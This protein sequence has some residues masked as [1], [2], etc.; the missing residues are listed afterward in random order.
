MPSN[1]NY[2]WNFGVL[3]G[4]FLVLQIVTGVVLAMHYAPNALVAFGTTEHIMR[5][6]NWGWLMRYAHANGASFFFIVAWTSI[7]VS[8]PK[9]T[10]ASSSVIRCTAASKG[11]DTNLP[12][13]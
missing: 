9:P 2:F 13:T 3:A 4:F 11:S 8:T 5:D 1:L 10:L 6:V 7:S 12:N